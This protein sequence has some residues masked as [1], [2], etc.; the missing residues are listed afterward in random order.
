MKKQ[1][2]WI[3]LLLFFVFLFLFKAI[4]VLSAL[5]SFVSISIFV[6]YFSEEKRLKEINKVVTKKDNPIKKEAKKLGVFIKE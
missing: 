5:F 2:K 6:F 1:I 3:F 4:G